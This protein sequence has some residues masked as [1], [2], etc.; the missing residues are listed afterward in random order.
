MGTGNKR[1]FKIMSTRS[2]IGMFVRDG[3]GNKTIRSVYVHSD[4]Y[5]MGVG[6]KL[7]DHWTDPAQIAALIAL[8]DLSVLGEEIGEKHDFDWRSDKQ[9]KGE[10]FWPNF[11]LIRADPRYKMCLAYARDRGETG[12]DAQ[13]HTSVDEFLRATSDCNGEWGYLFDPD[14]GGWSVTS[15]SGWG[16]IEEAVEV[17]KAERAAYEAQRKAERSLQPA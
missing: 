11:D 6:Q 8:G 10:G 1:E 13:T 5:P 2:R 14:N 7:L 3:E 17:E 12:V 16:T 4:G 15:G 9:F